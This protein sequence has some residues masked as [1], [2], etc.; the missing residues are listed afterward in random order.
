MHVEYFCY[1]FVAPLQQMDSEYRSLPCPPSSN[2]FAVLVLMAV[3]VLLLVLVL[4]LVLL[5]DAG[6]GVGTL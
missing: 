1:L 5:P 6:V 3:L 4:T 2:L